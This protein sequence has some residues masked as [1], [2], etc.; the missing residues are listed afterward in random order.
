E[1]G[2]EGPAKHV[3][4]VS[5]VRVQSQ[6]RLQMEGS[7]RAGGTL[8]PAR[9]NSWPTPFAATNFAAV[10]ESNS[11][12][13]PPASELGQPQTCSSIAQRIS[14]STGADVAD[15]WQVAQAN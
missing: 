4:I 12:D 7:I 11:S 6:E 2:F 9:S 15:D 3:A 10:V 13:A 14:T 1:V 8:R 5:L